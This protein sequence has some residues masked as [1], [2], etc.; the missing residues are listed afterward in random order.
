MTDEVRSLVNK[1]AE[2]FDGI[3]TD[4]DEYLSQA[5]IAG[6]NDAMS[7]ESEAV[8]QRHA[9]TMADV[10]S[11]LEHARHAA[12]AIETVFGPAAEAMRSH[13][14]RVAK[15]RDVILTAIEKKMKTNDMKFNVRQL[16]GR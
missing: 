9:K 7:T 8:L 14:K 11:L 1:T 5:E 10:Q 16:K 13:L 2:E 4:S 15:A 6:I 12:T 3:V